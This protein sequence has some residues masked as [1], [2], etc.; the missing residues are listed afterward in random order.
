MLVI[1]SV[2][3]HGYGK[4]EIAAVEGA[5]F[6]FRSQVSRYAGSQVCH[7]LD[8]DD[9]PSLELVEVEDNKAYV[10]FVPLGMPPYSPGISVVVPEW[11]ERDLSYF[12]TKHASLRPY[13]VHV[14]YDGSPDPRKPGWNYLN[15]ALPVVRGLYIFLTLPDEPAP[16]RPAPPRHPN[17]ARRVRGLVIDGDEKDLARLQNISESEFVDGGLAIDGVRVWPRTAFESLPRLGRKV[18][19][20]LAVVLEV[21]DLADLPRNVREGH[22][23]TFRGRPA[24]H[25][26]QNDLFGDLVITE[27]R[28]ELDRVPLTPPDSR[29][30]HP[31]GQHAF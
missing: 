20:L 25:L 31:R 12:E 22:D 24:V 23:A 14:P 4:E 8:F 19:P 30:P 9:G 3:G 13:R 27:S 2:Y 11:A 6:T 15:F 18:Y 7:W 10:D 1:S 28:P 16:R 21:F 29:R 17:G 5:G 26:P